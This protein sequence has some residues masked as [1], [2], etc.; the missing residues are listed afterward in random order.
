MAILEIDLAPDEQVYLEHQAQQAGLPISD[1]V[2]RRLSLTQPPMEKSGV[3]FTTDAGEIIEFP[4]LPTA[5]G[6]TTAPLRPFGLCA[7]EFTVPDDFDTPMELVTVT[8]D[9]G[10]DHERNTHTKRN[11]NTL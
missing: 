2:R 4:G 7:G 9:G 8:T 6:H 5:S 3:F 10:E 1:W 11:R